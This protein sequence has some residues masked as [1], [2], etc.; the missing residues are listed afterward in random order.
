MACRML[1]RHH[2]LC[3]LTSAPICAV[4]HTSLESPPA[5]CT[6]EYE[7]CALRE[8]T[9]RVSRESSVHHCLSL[10]AVLS[11]SLRDSTT[12]WS[13]EASNTTGVVVVLGKT[14][15]VPSLLLS[16]TAA[17]VL[18][19]RLHPR[20]PVSASLTVYRL[21]LNAV[22]HPC[23]SCDAS[24]SAECFEASLPHLSRSLRAPSTSEPSRS[25]QACH[26]LEVRTIMFWT[27]RFCIPLLLS[28]DFGLD[29]AC[30]RPRPS[31]TSG[32]DSRDLWNILWNICT[33]FS[34][35]LLGH[36][37]LLWHSSPPSATLHTCPPAVG[38]ALLSWVLGSQSLA[39]F[40]SSRPFGTCFIHHIQ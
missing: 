7:S 36:T 32:V 9:L 27:L 11:F 13:A 15:C 29:R 19:A 18:R 34:F 35:S 6:R 21:L 38:H 12:V 5:G 10:K 40:L 8:T 26:L 37:G 24:T 28:W 20:A 33:R 17:R 2:S 31:W 22:R 3:S 30:I 39:V 25:S 14:S 1:S 23:L 4:L 16:C